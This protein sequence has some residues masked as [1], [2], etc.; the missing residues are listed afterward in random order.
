[1]TLCIIQDKKMNHLTFV[2]ITCFQ[3]PNLLRAQKH[4]FAKILDWDEITHVDLKTAIE[5]ALE[6]KEMSEALDRVNR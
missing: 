4:G 6:D 3:K 1:M 5:E 2:K